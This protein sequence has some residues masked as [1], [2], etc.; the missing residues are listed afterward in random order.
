[1]MTSSSLLYIVCLPKKIFVRLP[2]PNH[3]TI[4]KDNSIKQ[5]DE[6]KKKSCERFT[7]LVIIII[8]IIEWWDEI[9]QRR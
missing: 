6:E 9:D 1:M 4:T 8:I 7:I 2:T 3:D 5:Q